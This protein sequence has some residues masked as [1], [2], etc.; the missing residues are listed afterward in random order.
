MFDDNRKTIEE[1][2]EQQFGLQGVR[3]EYSQYVPLQ[4]NLK[5][6]VPEGAALP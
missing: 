1:A 6:S 2:F 4:V 5:I 3:A